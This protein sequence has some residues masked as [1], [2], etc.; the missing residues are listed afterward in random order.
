MLV[1]QWAIFD[2]RSCHRGGNTLIWWKVR[3]A[4]YYIDTCHRASLLYSFA[5][6]VILQFVNLSP[7]SASLTL[8]FSALPI[9]F[10]LLPFQPTWFMEFRDTENQFDRHIS[11]VTCQNTFTVPWYCDYSRDCG[12]G[13]L[14]DDLYLR[15]IE[16]VFDD[17]QILWSESIYC[18]FRQID[19]GTEN[20]T[21]T[22]S[23][24]VPTIEVTETMLK[25]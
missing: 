4:G 6:L 11:S 16:S 9:A 25:S 17:R 18:I 20:I 7:Y 19:G 3:M 24:L 12:F 21:P 10:L 13:A 8:L 23:V 2:D 1:C 15:Y 5:S 14:F 22:L